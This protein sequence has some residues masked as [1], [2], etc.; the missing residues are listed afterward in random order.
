MGRKHKFFFFLSWGN[1]E[2]LKRQLLV[3]HEISITNEKSKLITLILRAW[4]GIYKY[5]CVFNTQFCTGHVNACH[6]IW[7]SSNQNGAFE[8]FH[9]CKCIKWLNLPE[10]FTMIWPTYLITE[11]H[12]LH[13]LQ[14]HLHGWKHDYSHIQKM[15]KCILLLHVV[16]NLRSLLFLIQDNI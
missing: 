5:L 4:R 12:S 7:N 6:R 14:E 9:T 13:F 16:N 8:M 3:L 2:T 11:Q 10:S 15:L 1:M